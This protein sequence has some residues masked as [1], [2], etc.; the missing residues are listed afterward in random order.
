MLDPG[1]WMLDTWML[2]AGYWILEPGYSM[3]AIQQ[4]NHYGQLPEDDLLDLWDADKCKFYRQRFEHRAE[5]YDQVIMNRLIGSSGSNRQK[6]LQAAKDAMPEA[7][8]GC[9][10]CHYLYGI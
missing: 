8:G 3:L 7:P 4:S 2:A 10:V 1:F 5:K 9:N 6:T